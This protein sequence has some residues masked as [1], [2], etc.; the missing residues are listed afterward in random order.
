MSWV[1][2]II[3]LILYSN[4]W[5]AVGALALCL[6]TAHLLQLELPPALLFFVFSSTLFLYALHRIVG[7]QKVKPFQD[8]GRY[9]VISTFRNHI[10]IYA[11]LGGLAAFVSFWYLNWNVQL[12]LIIPAILSLGYVIPVLTGNKRFRDVHF[13]K[14]FMIA[15]VWAAITVLLPTLEADI[16]LHASIM[17]MFLERASFI[18]AITIPFDIRDLSID[19]HTAVKTI[20]STFGIPKSKLL[21][22][23]LLG[24]MLLLAYLNVQSGVYSPNTLIALSLSAF[25]SSALVY[26]SDKISHDYYFTG[27]IDGMML[28]QYLLVFLLL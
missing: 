16:P 11:A 20:P 10:I 18:F 27:L 24:F 15:L 7:L 19:E 12:A 17:W 4:F 8:K 6:Q 5:I 21:A 23:S 26:Y 3:D 2:K 28:V 9:L 14:I 22:V 13:V 25:L 1:R